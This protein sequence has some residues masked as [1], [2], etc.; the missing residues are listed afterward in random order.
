MTKSEIKEEEKTPINNKNGENENELKEKNPILKE[1]ETIEEK[2]KSTQEKLLRTLA[3]MENQ[4][5]RFEKEK[6]EAFEFGGYNFAAE[7]L[8]LIDNLDRAI[9]SFKNDESLKKNEDL[10]KIIEGIEIVK[11]DLIS[12]FKKNGIEAIDCINKKFDPN[13][14]QAM[15]EVEND[16]KEPGT[17]VQEIQKGYMMK[18]R[19][20]RPSLVGVAKKRE[21]KGKKK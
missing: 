5:R 8:L 15:L 4:R 17:V 12:I 21:E 7:S 6:K 1:D 16:N 13:F 20:L 18:E 2:Y 14:H 3:E 10:D 9:I 11:K 19:L